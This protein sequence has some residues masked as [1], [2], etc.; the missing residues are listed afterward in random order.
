MIVQTMFG[1]NIN[2]LKYKND[3]IYELDVL[4]DI[5][6]RIV[7]VS[8]EVNREILKRITGLDDEHKLT[9][10]SLESLSQNTLLDSIC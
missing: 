9:E 8:V 1:K 3:Y 4:V 5:L 10:E 7:D 2:L 6:N